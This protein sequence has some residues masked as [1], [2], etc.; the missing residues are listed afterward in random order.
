[1]EKVRLGLIGTGG[2]MN[3]AHIPGYLNCDR[4]EITAICDINP[5]AL[6]KTGDRLSIPEEHRYTDYHDLL[7]CGLIDAVDIATSNDWH[8][9]IALDALDAGFPVSVEKPVGMDFSQSL[10]LKKKSEE[11]GLPVF[12]CFSWRYRPLPRYMKYLIGQGEIGEVYHMFLKNTKNSGLWPGRRMEWRFREEKASSGVLCDLGS[13]MFDLIRFLGE[14][15][16]GVYCDRGIIVKERQL[17]DSEEWEKVTTDDWSNVLCT[18]KSGRSATVTVTRATLT[19]QDTHEIYVTGS[20]G[21]LRF[22]HQNG[23]QTLSICKGEDLDTFTFREL[24]IPE[25][26]SHVT[27]SESYVSLVLGERD[28]YASTI[29]EGIYSQAIVD[30]AKLSSLSGRQIRIAEMM[31]G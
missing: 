7:K 8:V 3:G 17:P 10:Q 30:A 15:V 29:E 2:I 1:M 6:K 12:I 11:T 4:C 24:E 21:G 25:D 9:P 14:E 22:L 23:V 31:E 28:A 20:K 27:Q 19:E 5:E 18:L 13:H 26:F 16:D